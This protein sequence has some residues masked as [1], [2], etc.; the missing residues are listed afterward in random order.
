LEEQKC[1]EDY[2]NTMLDNTNKYRSWY[3]L[4]PL[5]V[6]KKLQYVALLA[7]QRCHV[8]GKDKA[9]ESFRLFVTDIK[10]SFDYNTSSTECEKIA[11]A[12]FY[13]EPTS[14]GFELKNTYMSCAVSIVNYT[15]CQVCFYQND[16]GADKLKANIVSPNININLESYNDSFWTQFPGKSKLN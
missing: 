8:L 6:S 1:Q 15:A 11:A 16:K 10:S 3:G 4:E 2:Q 9:V 13:Q 7:A 5:Q 12:Y 14:F